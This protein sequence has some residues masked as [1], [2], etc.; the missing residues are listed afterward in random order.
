MP[1]T[2]ARSRRRPTLGEDGCLYTG[3]TVDHL[4]SDG[5]MDVVSP[6]TRVTQLLRNARACSDVEG[7]HSELAVNMPIPRTA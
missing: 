4:N 6:L 2:N 3:P 7:Q 1:P 5:T